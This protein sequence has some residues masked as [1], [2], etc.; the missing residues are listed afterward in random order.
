MSS[1]RLRSKAEPWLKE[2]G[3][4]WEDVLPSLELVDS[5]EELREALTNPEAF[6]TEL[7]SKDGLAAR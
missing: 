6:F 4:K 2:Q 5:E 1:A 3:L 7:E